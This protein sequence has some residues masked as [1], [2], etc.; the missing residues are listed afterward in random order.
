MWDL[1]NTNSRELFKVLGTTGGPPGSRSRH[2]GIKR[3]MLTIILYSLDSENPI[4]IGFC[5]QCVPW[6]SRNVRD[7]IRDFPTRSWRPRFNNGQSVARGL[8]EGCIWSDW[9]GGVGIIRESKK[10]C[11]VV[12]EWSVGWNVGF[13][14][15]RC[16]CESRWRTFEVATKLLRGRNTCCGDLCIATKRFQALFGSERQ[17]R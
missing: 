13:L 15:N 4:F 12:S 10:I 3:P 5:V 1:R 11:P 8:K 17:C 6:L 9:S 7:E 14:S 2:L 16:N